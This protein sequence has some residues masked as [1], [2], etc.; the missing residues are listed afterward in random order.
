[1]RLFNT[2][3]Q[4]I[5]EFTSPDGKVRIYVCGV[6]PY[7]TTHIGH[8][9]T[10]LTFDILVRYLRFQGYDVTYVQNVTDID[11]DVL[12]KAKE[13]GMDWRALGTQETNQFLE[14]LRN[15]NAVEFDHYVAATEHIAE[16]VTNVEKLI[17]D[18]VA[19]EVNGSVYYSVAK[20]PEFGK[21]S[22]L[23]RDEMLPIANERGNNPNDPNKQDPLDFVLWQAAA[24]GE[25][26]WSSPW[27]EGRP[28]WHIECSAMATTYLGPQIDIHG[29][30][31]DLVFPHHECEIAQA[32][33]ATG[34]E[35]FV[36]YWMHVGMTEYEGEK[37]SKSLGNLVYVKDM[38]KTYASDAIRL[39]L[40]AHHYRGPWL[41]LD[42]EMQEWV[43]V[44]EDLQRAATA[45]SDDG[46]TVDIGQRRSAFFEAMDNDLDTPTAIDVLRQIAAGIL[47][48]P[49]GA[50]VSDAQSTLRELGDILG[51]TLCSH[52]A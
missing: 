17:A 2:Q 25:P 32:E 35:P 19:Y 4:S 23:S 20:D 47:E 46:Q 39:Y 10:F 33:T 26:T 38:L 21:L 49:D 5:E 29:G 30:G 44:A 1:M 7:D 6:T 41:F 31:Y 27:G 8:A 18:G 42:D 15:L 50:N 13:L 14:D 9:F 28:G 37:M 34:V 48:A 3:S 40:H 51:L 52:R 16:I 11:D 43:T 12:R 36:R 24:P 22:H 45:A